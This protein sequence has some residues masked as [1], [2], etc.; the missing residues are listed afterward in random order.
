MRYV[1]RTYDAS[2]LIDG[3]PLTD[4]QASDWCGRAGVSLPGVGAKALV[5]GAPDD[6]HTVVVCLAD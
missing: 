2:C 1:L 6:R 4:E 5:D 3:L